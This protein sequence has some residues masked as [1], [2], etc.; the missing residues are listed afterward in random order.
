MNRPPL[1]GSNDERLTTRRRL[2]QNKN[3]AKK[4]TKIKNNEAGGGTNEAIFSDQLYLMC[5]GFVWFL[6]QL[7]KYWH[8]S[9]EQ[10][11]K[12]KKKDV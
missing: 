2:G 5:E 6:F 12:R 10:K 8:P 4:K 7:Y 1:T 3:N 9:C 11:N